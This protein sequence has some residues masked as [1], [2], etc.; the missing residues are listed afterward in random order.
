MTT[1][2]A[3]IGGPH[4]QQMTMGPSS[5]QAANLGPGIFIFIIIIFF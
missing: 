3:S 2:P 4:S 1:G 5:V